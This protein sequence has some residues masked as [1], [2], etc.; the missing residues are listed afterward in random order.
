[1]A[2]YAGMRRMWE[3]NSCTAAGRPGKSPWRDWI[4]VL[5]ERKTKMNPNNGDTTR[6]QEELF[7]RAA[8]TWLPIARRV[9][10]RELAKEMDCPLDVIRRHF[11][12]A[13][14][15]QAKYGRFAKFVDSFVC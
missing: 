13:M 2:E 4:V 10:L 8:A 6:K 9:L 12:L 1:M 14:S 15:G 11:R 5:P 3:N 7:E